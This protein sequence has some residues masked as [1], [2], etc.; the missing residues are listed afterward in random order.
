MVKF[1][2]I[3][4]LLTPFALRAD[5][6]DFVGGKS[7]S[8]SPLLLVID[9]LKSFEVKAGP[10]F[11]DNFNQAVKGVDYAIEQEKLYCSGEVANKKGKVIPADKKQLCVRELKK[12]YIEVTGLI[13]EIKRKYLSLVH[14]IQ[15][16]Q[17]TNIEEDLKNSIEKN[18]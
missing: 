3:F 6:F 18:F 9:K 7:S 1:I 17:L 5:F 11:E 16:K 10:E 12:R 2:L 15:L 8:D 14:D 13:F 4:C